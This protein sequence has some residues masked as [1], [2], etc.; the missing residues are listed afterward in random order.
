[1]NCLGLGAREA[2]CAWER[3]GCAIR[4]QDGL[5][6]ALPLPAV[7]A[8]EGAELRVLAALPQPPPPRVGLGWGR[9]KG[10]VVFIAQPAL[11]F[12]EKREQRTPNPPVQGPHSHPPQQGPELKASKMGTSR[13][14]G[15]HHSSLYAVLSPESV[16]DEAF[17]RALRKGSRPLPAGPRP[18]SHSCALP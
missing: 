14:F 17:C 1:M 13:N 10:G 6:P 4:S 5:V 3:G 8:K 12:Q 18:A 9:E 11:L 15:A 7:T 16:E 2:A